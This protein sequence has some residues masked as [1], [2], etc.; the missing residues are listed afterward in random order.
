MIEVKAASADSS[1]SLSKYEPEILIDGQK[2]DLRCAWCLDVSSPVS[3]G[4]HHII[5]R[6]KDHKP[7]EKDVVVE[8]WEDLSVEVKLER[9]ASTS[10]AKPK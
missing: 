9:I 10:W 2:I 3:I 5:V 8:G 4:K 6:A 1:V 7:A